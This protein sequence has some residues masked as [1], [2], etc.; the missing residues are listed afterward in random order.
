MTYCCSELV[1]STCKLA[2]NGYKL[3]ELEDQAMFSAAAGMNFTAP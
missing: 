3:A 2:C 1:P